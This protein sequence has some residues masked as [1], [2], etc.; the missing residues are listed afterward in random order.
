[1][2]RQ[3]LFFLSLFLFSSVTLLRL[4]GAFHL[5]NAYAQ[6]A[7]FV[8]TWLPAVFGVVDCFVRD[9]GLAS[10]PDAIKK[11]ASPSTDDNSSLIVTP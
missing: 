6:Q 7:V 5:D 4:Y 11:N 1:M 10:L 9:P 3:H 8:L 2:Q